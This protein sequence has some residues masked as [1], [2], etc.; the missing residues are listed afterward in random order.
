MGS[1]GLPT[2]KTAGHS[3]ETSPDL[4]LQAVEDPVCPLGW[5]SGKLGE[6]WRK[7]RQKE[8]AEGVWEGLDE[9]WGEGGCM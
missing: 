8:G 1:Q 6:G 9:L 7:L 2:M 4:P 5:A 3:F